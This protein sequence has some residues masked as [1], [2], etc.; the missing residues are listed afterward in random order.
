MTEE[1]NEKEIQNEKIDPLLK[2]LIEIMKTIRKEMPDA[3]KEE[4]ITIFLEYMRERGNHFGTEKQNMSNK[5]H[6]DIE[7]LINSISFQTAKDGNSKYAHVSRLVAEQLPEEFVIGNDK[8]FVK[9]NENEAVIIKVPK[10]F[11]KK[12]EQKQ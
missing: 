7:S 12:N 9:K 8:Y 6:V 2:E 1:K 4:R 3:E 11:P 10:K 5:S